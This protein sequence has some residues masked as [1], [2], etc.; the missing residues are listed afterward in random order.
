MSLIDIIIFGSAVGIDDVCSFWYYF[1]EASPVVLDDR[2]G[3]ACI[4][5]CNAGSGVFAG[6]A[7]RILHASSGAVQAGNGKRCSRHA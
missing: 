7:H 2:P 4:E 6:V 1:C 3:R 5:R